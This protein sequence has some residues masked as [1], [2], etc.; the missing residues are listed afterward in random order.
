VVYSEHRGASN[1]IPDA[2]IAD[3]APALADILVSEDRRC[4]E[5]S[6]KISTRFLPSHCSGPEA[7]V[8]RPP[9]AERERWAPRRANVVKLCAG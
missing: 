8:A 2:I 5:R 9:A 1:E 6:K 3:S 4:R 7:R